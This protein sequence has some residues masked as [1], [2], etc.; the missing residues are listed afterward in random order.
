MARQYPALN[1]VVVVVTLL[2]AEVD[3]Y[4]S[5]S[6]SLRRSIPIKMEVKPPTPGPAPTGRGRPTR[7]D[8]DTVDSTVESDR[9]SKKSSDVMELADIEPVDPS[10]IEVCI[11]VC[12]D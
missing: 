3:R 12:I 1:D 2:P 8:L 6:R 11:Y 5:V 10:M 9:V 7:G 4:Y